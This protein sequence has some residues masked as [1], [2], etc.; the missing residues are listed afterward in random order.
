MAAQPGIHFLIGNDLGVL[1]PTETEG[2][3]KEPC[4]D[5]LPGKDVDDLRARAEIYLGGL[6]RSKVQDGGDLRMRVFWHQYMLLQLLINSEAHQINLDR[7]GNH[8]A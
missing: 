1:M 3:D 6:A 7:G 4:L 5:H 8:S 2:H